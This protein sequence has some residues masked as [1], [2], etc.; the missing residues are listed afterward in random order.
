[1]A[2]QLL[3]DLIAHVISELG[4][5]DA[6]FGKTKLVKLLYLIDVEDYRR[7][8]R[9]LSGL[10]WVYYH[11]GPYAFDIDGALSEM[12]LDVPSESIETRRGVSAIVFKPSRDLNPDLGRHVES[13]HELRLV[14]RVINS[15]ALTDLNALLNHVYFYTEPMRDAHRGDVLDFSKIDRSRKVPTR[16]QEPAISSERIQE[17]RARLRTSREQRM[18]VPLEPA[19]RYDAVYLEGLRRMT[20]EEAYTLPPGAID[21]PETVKERLRARGESLDG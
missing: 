1:M 9:S 19:P 15:W 7:F 16:P 5:L 13:N 8:G 20:E 14:N 12:S 6:S 21:I 18:P 4:E 3:R 2:S 10:E 17:F 11:Y